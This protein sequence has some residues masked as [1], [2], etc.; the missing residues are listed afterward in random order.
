[1]TFGDLHQL[2]EELLGFGLGVGAG[3]APS[4]IR[5]L[6][7]GLFEKKVLTDKA[8]MADAT[9]IRDGLKKLMHAK[10]LNRTAELA[11]KCYAD[12][13]MIRASGK[14]EAEKDRDIQQARKDYEAAVI[15]HQYEL[16]QQDFRKVMSQLEDDEV[17]VFESWL[18]NTL[19][20]EE[21]AQVLAAR[22]FINEPGIIKQAI[23]NCLKHMAASGQ[24]ADTTYSQLYKRWGYVETDDAWRVAWQRASKAM[25]DHLMTV[26]PRLPIMEQANEAISALLRG[27]GDRNPVVQ[28]GRKFLK[29]NAAERVAVA[30]EKLAK[31]RRGE[32]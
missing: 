24:T 32:G 12:I 6:V 9:G 17:F 7:G 21:K 16:T 15:K 5:G 23:K 4:I 27:E 30:K 3:A 20:E 28:S 13:V 2:A 1:M 14:S 29:E 26:L 22:R 8:E 18:N 25:F 11:D 10:G 31:H 19:T